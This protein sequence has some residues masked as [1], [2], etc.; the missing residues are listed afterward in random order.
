MRPCNILESLG[1]TPVTRV[2]TE[3]FRTRFNETLDLQSTKH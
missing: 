1:V 3:G 2:L